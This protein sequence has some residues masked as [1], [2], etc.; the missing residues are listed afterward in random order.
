MKEGVDITKVLKKTYVP[1][2]CGNE[3]VN[4]YTIYVVDKLPQPRQHIEVGNKEGYVVSIDY[5][6][7][8]SSNIVYLEKN[9]DD[10]NNQL[11]E[12]CDSIY[13]KES[14]KNGR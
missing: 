2:Y 4:R 13:L 5:D 8:T 14:E 3:L 7:E 10:W 1:M 12:V 11:C 6:E 9:L